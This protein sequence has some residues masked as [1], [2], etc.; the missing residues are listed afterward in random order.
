MDLDDFLV[1]LDA[2]TI[3][4]KLLTKLTMKGSVKENTPS[5][6]NL[7]QYTWLPVIPRVREDC[8]GQNPQ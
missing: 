3:A 7:E 1:H 8:T 4:L 5:W 2:D 6:Q